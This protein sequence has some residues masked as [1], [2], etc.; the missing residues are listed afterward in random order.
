MISKKLLIKIIVITA[1]NHFV[2][3]WVLMQVDGMYM[4][5]TIGQLGST[6]CIIYMLYTMQNY[7]II[8][9]VL[10]TWMAGA[11]IYNVKCC[12]SACIAIPQV[13]RINIELFFFF[14]EGPSLEHHWVMGVL[15][16]RILP[17]MER[18]IDVNILDHKIAAL[19]M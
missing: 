13:F 15:V 4:Y 3:L 9:M 14:H 18:Y 7:I 19:L 2:S 12:N 1:R 17:D 11:I 8:N 10:S 6:L 5:K 16:L